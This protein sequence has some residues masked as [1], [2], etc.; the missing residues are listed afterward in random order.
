MISSIN[1]GL[2]LIYEKDINIFKRK[3]V[4]LDHQ[5]FLLDEFQ[6][7]LHLFIIMMN[8]ITPFFHV[9]GEFMPGDSLKEY[10][11]PTMY[12]TEKHGSAV[13]YLNCLVDYVQSII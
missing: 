12:L 11:I 2:H 7:Q 9:R 1:A 3:K 13:E 8:C 4:C 5:K 6:N 10:P